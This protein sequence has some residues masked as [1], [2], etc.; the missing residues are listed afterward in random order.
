MLVAVEEGLRKDA[1]VLSTGTKIVNV[2]SQAGIA[3]VGNAGILTPAVTPG[4][5]APVVGVL[6]T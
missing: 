3:I 5:S 1:L 6:R 4:R 2:I